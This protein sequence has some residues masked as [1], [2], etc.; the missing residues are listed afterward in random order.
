MHGNGEGQGELEAQR[1]G[2]AKNMREAEIELEAEK[3]KEAQRLENKSRG[4]KRP[5]M[6]CNAA[7]AEGPV[8][9]LAIAPDVTQAVGDPERVVQRGGGPKPS[10]PCGYLVRLELGTHQSPQMAENKDN[11]HR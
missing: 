6:G 8:S 9:G 4:P 10:D 5:S 3:A 7:P 2:V 1:V 11:R